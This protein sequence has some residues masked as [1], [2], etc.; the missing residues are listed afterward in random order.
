VPPAMRTA[1]G[2]CA[3]GAQMRMRCGGSTV[4]RCS[5]VQHAEERHWPL[6]RAACLRR[7][8]PPLMP[9]GHQSVLAASPTTRAR[10]LAAPQPSRL[11]QCSADAAMLL[12]SR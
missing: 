2:C 9:K 11:G 7:S 6:R 8:P 10:A 5:R 4:I 3:R 1:A 12:R